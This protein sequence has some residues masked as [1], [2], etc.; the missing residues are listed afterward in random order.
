[1]DPLSAVLDLLRPRSCVCHGIDM[2]DDL[3]FRFGRHEG[4]KCYAVVSGQF[5]LS[6]QGV[7]APLQVQAGDCFLLPRALPLAIGS[8]LAAS[9]TD[10][11]NDAVKVENGS[12]LTFNGGG[13]CFVVGGYFTIEGA[14][15]E[16]LVGMLPPIVHVRSEAEKSDLRWALERMRR[17]LKE[18]QPGAELIVQQLASMIF[19]QTL[20]MHLK[21]RTTSDRGWLFALGDIQLRSAL[22]AIHRAPSDPWTVGLLARHAGMSRSLFA[23]RFKQA[24]GETPLQY[25]T[26][27]RILLASEKLLHTRNSVG[28]IASSSGYASEAAFRAAFHRVL[29]CSPRRYGS[30]RLAGAK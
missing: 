4:M 14:H 23:Q 28:E 2:A 12:I 25:L 16:T 11:L 29:G 13:S 19:V 18:A 9:A 27:W 20:R 26:R 10:A 22:T 30:R 24:V 3:V 5:W 17:E 15:A 1:M 21:E 6:L 8:S 7:K